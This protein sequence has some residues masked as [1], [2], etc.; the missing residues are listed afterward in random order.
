MHSGNKPVI[1][2]LYRSL[3][4]LLGFIL[5]PLSWWNDL[6]VNVPLAYALSYPFSLINPSF[7]L[8]AFVIA[9]WVSNLVGFLLIHY[10]VRGLSQSQKKTGA[11]GRMIV[12]TLFYTLLIVILVWLNWLPAPNELARHLQ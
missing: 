10:S 7:F 1:R 6:F 4:A 9:Y 3:L 5:S 12:I 2:S 11:P 8:P